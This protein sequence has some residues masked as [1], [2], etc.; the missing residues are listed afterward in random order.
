MVVMFKNLAQSMK[1]TQSVGALTFICFVFF[2]PA[3][4]DFFRLLNFY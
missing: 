3:S 2:N 4:G 1:T